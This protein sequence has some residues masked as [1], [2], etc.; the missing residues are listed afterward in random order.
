MMVDMSSVLGTQL[1]SIAQVSVRAVTL[2][3]YPLLTQ[4]ILYLS[5]AKEVK[6]MRLGRGLQPVPLTVFFTMMAVAYRLQV[7]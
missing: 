2:E 7:L 4:P 6:V 1:C 3:S 5:T